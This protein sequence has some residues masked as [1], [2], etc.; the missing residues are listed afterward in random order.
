MPHPC[1]VG[2]PP[3]RAPGVASVVAVALCLALAAQV[4][5]GS[6]EPAPAPPGARATLKV[7]PLAGL[8]RVDYTIRVENGAHA[9][10]NEVD[11]DSSAYGDGRGSLSYVTPC[12]ATSNDNTV[13]LTITDIYDE[14][15]AL[16]PPGEWLNPTPVSVPF[17][18]EP[19]A[20]VAV[21]INL[22][23]ARAAKR[24]FFDIGVSFDDVFCSAKLDCVKDG[25][26]LDLL[27]NPATGA[28]DLTAVLGFAC[29]AGAGAA[30]TFLYLDNPVITCVGGIAP[31][32]VDV[33][34][35]GNVD[36]ASPPSG[37]PAHT[38]FG[39]AVYRG[40]GAQGEL[41]YWNVALGLDTSHIGAR[42][43]LRV[44][45]TAA[46]RAFVEGVG[47]FETPD[48]WTWPFIEWDVDLADA[49]GRLC[50]SHPLDAAPP[51]VAT[52]YTGLTAPRRFLHEYRRSTDEVR[53]ASGAVS[54]YDA[55]Q[56]GDETGVDCG[57]SCVDCRVLTGTCEDGAQNQ[58]ETGLDCG[59]ATCGPCGDGSPCELDRDCLSATCDGA[60]CRAPACDDH[61]QNG[62]E[63]G[64]DCGG[65][66]CLLCPGTATDD[67]EQCVTH[68]V[69]DGVCAEPSCTDGQRDGD[70][71]GPDCGGSCDPC[72]PG[73]PCDGAVD[74][75]TLVCGETVCEDARC[76]DGQQN[77]DEAGV[78][79]GGSCLACTGTP[80]TDPNVCASHVI[81]NGACAPPRCD[82]G[83][84]NGFETGQDCGG[85]C[86]PCEVGNPCDIDADCV[87]RVCAL[88]FCREP[89]CDDGRLDQDE[90]GIDCG[91]E[92]CLACTGTPVDDPTECA[93]GTVT[94]GVCAAPTCDDDTVN[95]GETGPD[96]GGPCA[97]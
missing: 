14:G 25:A 34:G 54:C 69:V 64:V 12:D 87:T 93:S 39:A 65:A 51:G 72:D 67:P 5:C 35:L 59:G 41:A 76:D 77:G 24:G 89:S 92:T 73:L 74:C 94:D 62:D 6:D 29:A 27:T 8:G 46:P 9:V 86:G 15:G 58:D 53:T 71:T 56:N 60:F 55:E 52:R 91:G 22:T 66:T 33:R 20:D 44:R 57:G 1:R 3:S 95:G 21:D 49:S 19:D 45:G 68:T 23:V 30:D 75:A 42:C 50:E 11:V 84:L 16:V 10:V 47:G 85:T 96:C 80:E 90:V 81:V 78:D 28:R 83:Q 82:D 2:A 40:P 61:R 97:P 63:T 13:I 37:D 17:T 32:V 4:G 79:C 7:A 43:T 38:L 26:D 31:T 88:G 48:G 70:E 18:C 36:L